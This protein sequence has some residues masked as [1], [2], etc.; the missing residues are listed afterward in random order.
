M[1]AVRS[2]VPLSG[3]PESGV[4]LTPRLA[5]ERSPNERERRPAMPAATPVSKLLRRGE[6]LAAAAA[7][8]G[9]AAAAEARRGHDCGIDSVEMTIP[10][11]SKALLGVDRV[12]AV[13]PCGSLSGEECG[14]RSEGE[15]LRGGGGPPCQ[16]AVTVDAGGICPQDYKIIRPVFE[17]AQRR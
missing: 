2:T 13:A 15:R 16:L 3:A 8:V 12:E 14:E 7:A 4:C 1:R 9:V 17:D 10:R 11:R 5:D 6:L